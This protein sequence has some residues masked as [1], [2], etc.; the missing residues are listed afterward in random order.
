MYL[1]I[2]NTYNT[3]YMYTIQ[4]IFYILYILY[5]NIFKKYKVLPFDSCGARE[6]HVRQ[7]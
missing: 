2:Y 3:Y 7:K 5:K 4:N 6:Y 1:C